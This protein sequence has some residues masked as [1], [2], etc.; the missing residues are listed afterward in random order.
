MARLKLKLQQQLL[1][2][3]LAIVFL[4]RLA[5]PIKQDIDDDLLNKATGY[6]GVVGFLIASLCG[7]VLLLSTLVLPLPIAVLISMGFGLML[8]GAFH[9]DGLADTADGFG[10]GWSTEQK[11]TIMK[12]SRLGTY[13]AS[14]LCLVLLIKFESLL[15]LA[16]YDVY[17]ALTSLVLAHVLSRVLA[18]SIIP[19][20]DYVQLDNETKTKPVAKSL[21]NSSVLPLTLSAVLVVLLSIPF[22][23]VT[24]YQGMGLLLVIT[25]IRFLFI[26]F[27]KKQI[28]GYTGDV[29]GAAQQ[30]FELLVY[31]F[32]L[33]FV[34]DF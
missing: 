2:F 7:A 12:D 24:L 33:A 5:L 30:I 9:E 28:G 6:F 27:I 16:Q 26:K 17:Y 34:G 1:L 22:V 8:T 18:I 3:K 25:L 10:G 23:S 11:L 14:S 19:S 4:T 21:S 29:L 15:W 13:G 20:L 32:M 31:F